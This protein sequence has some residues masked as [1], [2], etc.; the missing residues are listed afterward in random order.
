MRD[1]RGKN[2][3]STE[4]NVTEHENKKFK[5]CTDKYFQFDETGK[6][7]SSTSDYADIKEVTNEQTNKKSC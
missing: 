3:G 4:E 7:C 2:I 1:A 6:D 5:V